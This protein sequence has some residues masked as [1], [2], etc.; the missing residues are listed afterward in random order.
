M[1]TSAGQIADLNKRFATPLEKERMFGSTLMGFPLDVD[2]GRDI[3]F[4]SNLKQIQTLK[5]PEIPHVLTGYENAFG[6]VSHAYLQVKG[7]WEVVGKIEKFP[8]IYTLVLY[9]KE[10]NTYDMVEKRTGEGLTEK[11]G[12]LYNTEKMDSL[13]VGDVVKD[14]EVLYK[15]TSY[16]ENMNYRNGINALVM[17]QNSCSTIEDAI[18]ISR[19]FANRV[20]TFGIDRITV[21]INDND[22]LLLMHGDKE[23]GLR[24]LP[25]LGEVL[26]DTTLCATRRITNSRVLFDMR[27][28]RLTELL[29]TDSEYVVPTHTYVYDINV[30]YNNDKPFPDNVFFKELKEY[31]DA[32]CDYAAKLLE[33]TTKIKK[34]GSKYT[35]SITDIKAKV[36]H[37]NDPEY[38]WKGPKDTAFNNIMVEFKTVSEASVMTGSKLVGR[39]GDKGVVSIITDNEYS[40]GGSTYIN[41]S[42]F[43][44]AFADSTGFAVDD[45]QRFEIV[46]DEKMPYL[47]N[48]RRLDMMLNA[49]GA[50]RRVNP[51]QLYEVEINF[52]SECIRQHICTLKDPNEKLDI[53]FKYL[54]M[55]NPDAF[56]FYCRMCGGNIDAMSEIEIKNRHSFYDIFSDADKVVRDVFIQ[57]IEK[58][59]FYIHKPPALGIRYDEMRAIYEE[60]ADI[61]KPYQ[62]YVDKFGRKKIPVMRPAVVGDKYMYVLKQ[63]TKKNF[64]ARSTG[65]ITKAGIPAKSTDKKDN[66]I[67]DSNSPIRIGEIHNLFSQISGTTLATHN[68]F[69]RTSPLGRR[70]LKVILESEGNPLHIQELPVLKTYVNANVEMLMARFKTMGIGYEIVTDKTL[71]AEKVSNMKTFFEI[72]GMTF[73]DTLKNRPYYARLIEVYFSKVRAGYPENDEQTWEVVMNDDCIKIIEPPDEIVSMVKLAMQFKKVIT[74]SHSSTEVNNGT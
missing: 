52:C 36:Q 9:N 63:T 58:N 27:E 50:F 57:S 6:E 53:I 73:M 61:I 38:K 19:S 62:L 66:R 33:A 39:Y 34:S 21:S 28:E 12:Y 37:W 18:R 13:K 71:T 16:D 35:R 41:N 3:M 74:K 56:K 10:T 47:E 49:P 51:G 40:E 15:S 29:P 26:N 5:N 30:Y 23:H 65:R 72:H 4:A 22:V 31:Y 11:F 24:T 32:C 67:C 44:K 69:T 2:S 54:S 43:A 1:A 55:L 64:S 42:E 7:D 45:N 20:N 59:G 8:T 17:Y 14:K 48:G 70:A 46:P 68:I 60:F 25:K